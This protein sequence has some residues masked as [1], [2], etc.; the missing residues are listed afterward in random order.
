ML[1]KT[2]VI[3]FWLVAAMA[4]CNRVADIGA[5]TREVRTLPTARAIE[6]HLQEGRRLPD[7]QHRAGL[8]LGQGRR[9]QL[10]PGS[11]TRSE[12]FADY[13]GSAAFSEY[14]ELAQPLVGCS[15]DGS[16]GLGWSAGSRSRACGAPRTARSGPL[17]SPA[18]G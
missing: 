13:L 15:R 14:R 16:L 2:I 10:S 3:L 12:G 18:P 7:A 1:N 9:G 11:G 5:V 17:I 6:A 8:L 4:G